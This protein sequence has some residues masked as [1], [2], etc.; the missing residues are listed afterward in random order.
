MRFCARGSE[1][2][3]RSVDQFGGESGPDESAMTADGS[4]PNGDGVFVTSLVTCCAISD[5]S[6]G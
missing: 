5:L 1:V 4:P 6:I 3:L 2:N